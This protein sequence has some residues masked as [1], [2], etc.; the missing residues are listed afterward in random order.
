[1]AV[2]TYYTINSV[3]SNK[4]IVDVTQVD[5]YEP[6][7]P[8]GLAIRVPRGVGIQGKPK[9]LTE[10]LD[11]KKNGI[12]AAYDGL[13]NIVVDSCLNA[14][15]SGNGYPGI[16]TTSST[17]YVQGSGDASPGIGN[18]NHQILG[19]GQIVFLAVAIPSAPATCVLQWEAYTTWVNV[20]ASG[21]TYRYYTQQ[22]DTH[23]DGSVSFNG[24]STYTAV[25][26]GVMANIDS[27]SQ[28]SSVV[29][30]IENPTSFPI[31]LGSWALVF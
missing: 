3:S 17:K 20:T 13:S 7:A 14:T 15:G 23:L 31:Y 12:L 22:P 6:F 10:L 4:D 16:N 9:T 27:D 28:G 30:R 2:T 11:A 29:V 5:D 25:S 19:G 21:L 24:G 8:M 26:S 18:T 1:M